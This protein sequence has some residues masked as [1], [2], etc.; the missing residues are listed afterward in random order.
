MSCVEYVLEPVKG[1]L[2]EVGT[3]FIAGDR[4]VAVALFEY[5][6][7][8]TYEASFRRN[9]PVCRWGGRCGEP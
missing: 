4:A 5:D 1:D 6:T 3:T 8:A 9:V 2:V 7:G